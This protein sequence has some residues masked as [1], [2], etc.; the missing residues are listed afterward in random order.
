MRQQLHHRNDWP[1]KTD[2]TLPASALLPEPTS[3]TSPVLRVVL[4]RARVGSQPRAR[5]DNH[6]V[7]L[8]IEG[9]GMRGAVSAGMCVVLEALGLVSAFDRIYGV[10]AGAMNACAL[11]AGQAALAATHYEDAAIRGVINRMRPLV[12]RPVIDFELLFDE[13]IGARKPLSFEGLAAGPEFRALATSLETMSVRI[14]AGFAD[15]VEAMDAVRASAA[16]PGLG[17]PAPLFRGERMTDGGL[18]EPIPFETALAEG[19]SHVLV[20]RSRSAGY[21]KRSLIG[22]AEALA[23]RDDPRLVELLK[24]RQGT[25]NRLAAEL[26]ASHAT[27]GESSV[28]QIAVPDD[29][30]VIGRLET[31]ADRVAGAVRLGARAIASALVTGS[32]DVCWRPVVYRTGAASEEAPACG[33]SERRPRSALPAATRIWRH[34]PRPLRLAIR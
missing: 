10:S 19:A 30:R 28:L 1:E 21:R 12:R 23:L 3:V 24:Q 17:G 8:A 9:G 7:C 31:D 32:I 20:L 4:E 26:Q 29:S 33:G 11:A 25:Y 16:L 15:M 13:V 2:S 5:Q 18:T 34:A 6:L 22:A 27:Q 14:L